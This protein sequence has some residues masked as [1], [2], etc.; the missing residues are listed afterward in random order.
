MSKTTPE[1]GGLVQSWRP[2]P[3]CPACRRHVILGIRGLTRLAPRL[4]VL[5]NR[6]CMCILRAA[7]NSGEVR[8]PPDKR[9]STRTSARRMARG[10]PAV[11][12][13]EDFWPGAKERSRPPASRPDGE[14]QA[15]PPMFQKVSAA[16]K[17]SLSQR[18]KSGEPR[19]EFRAPP[20]C[21]AGRAA[22]GRVQVLKFPLCCL[23]LTREEVNVLY[24][25]PGFQV[26][27][28]L[29]QVLRRVARALRVVRAR[30]AS[31]G[32]SVPF[33]D[34]SPRGDVAWRRG[35]GLL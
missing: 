16:L 1:S 34:P 32:A 20:S 17:K 22:G 2:A 26:A 23:G 28:V 25:A 31:V 7:R 15:G 11:D 27:S 4:Q 10:S 6:E 35:A 5:D 13:S 12:A 30:G 19:D 21:V 29:Q 14:P 9:R 24:D 3:G 18:A 33:F 8:Y